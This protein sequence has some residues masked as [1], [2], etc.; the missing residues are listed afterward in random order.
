[1]IPDDANDTANESVKLFS[2]WFSGG[3]RQHLSWSLKRFS[4]WTRAGSHARAPTMEIQSAQWKRGRQL[5][6]IHSQSECSAEAGMPTFE[7]SDRST[8][9]TC[10]DIRGVTPVLVVLVVKLIW[11]AASYDQWSSLAARLEYSMAQPQHTHQQMQLTDDDRTI[12]WGK[13]DERHGVYPCASF[14]VYSTVDL[15]HDVLLID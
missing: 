2:W 11:A 4:P 7:S 1:M 14:F 8:L 9:A 5:E 13:T 3:Y 12:R 10:Q 6:K 15:K